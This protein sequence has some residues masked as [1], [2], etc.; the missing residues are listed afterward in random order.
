[1][2][3]ETRFKIGNTF[4]FMFAG[5]GECVAT[6]FAFI[7]S[8]SGSETTAHVLAATLA[9]L[10]FHQEEQEKVLSEIRGV[11][12]DDKDPVSMLNLFD[13]FQFEAGL[14]YRIMTMFLS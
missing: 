8:F 12:P 2:S 14:C 1:M 11:V 6:V 13:T 10:A 5:H 3:I 7:C 9:L 4:T